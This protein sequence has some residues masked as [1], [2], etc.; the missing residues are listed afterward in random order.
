[1]QAVYVPPQEK[2][3]TI[4]LSAIQGERDSIPTIDA[5]GCLGLAMDGSTLPNSTS[6]I[7]RT[8]HWYASAPH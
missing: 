2:D 6:V 4:D 7:L 5:R 8:M 3:E 1:M